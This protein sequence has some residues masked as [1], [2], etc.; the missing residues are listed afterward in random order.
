VRMTLRTRN[1]IEDSFKEQCPAA[2]LLTATKLTDSLCFSFYTVCL[3]GKLIP[4]AE[5]NRN[6]LV[7]HTGR[8]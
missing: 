2:C 3:A 8:R 1:T 5:L 4:S 6:A 7:Y